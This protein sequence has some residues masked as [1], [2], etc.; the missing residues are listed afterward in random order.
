M[1]WAVL[2]RQA[3]FFSALSPPWCVVGGRSKQ[4]KDTPDSGV[5][6]CFCAEAAAGAVG[7]SLMCQ[8][9]LIIV[10]DEFVWRREV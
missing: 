2:I 4:H 6:A 10:P 7:A 5:Y 9:A 1:C 8:S 3:A